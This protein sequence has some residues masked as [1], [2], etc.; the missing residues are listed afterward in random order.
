MRLRW[1]GGGAFVV[2]ELDQVC[3]R[4]HGEAPGRRFGCVSVRSAGVRS[5][6]WS[7]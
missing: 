4:V 2:E 7:A 5:T 1:N 3:R 6:L